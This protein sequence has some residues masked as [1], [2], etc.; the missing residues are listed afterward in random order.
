MHFSILYN[1]ESLGYAFF[2]K[3]A[4]PSDHFANSSMPSRNL[5]ILIISAVV[6]LLCYRTATRHHYGG[7]L[8]SAIGKINESFVRP[9]DDRELFEGA[10]HGMVRQLDPHSVYISPD[11]VQRFQEELDQE[12]GGIGIVVEINAT[13]RRLTVLSPLPDTPAF[14]AGMRA[15]DV[16]LDINDESTE[17]FQI[18][19][20][21]GLMRG[22]PGT[23]LTLTIQHA[24]AT[25]PIGLKLT[26]AIIP[27]ASVLGDLRNPDGSWQFTLQKHPRIGYIRLVGFGEHTAD[28]LS[29]TIRSLD[30]RID[31]LVI[32]LRGNGGGLLE[33]AVAVC[34]LFIDQGT[35][36]SIRGRDPRRWRDYTASPT[37]TLLLSLP[38][39]V[40]VDGY[41]ASASEIMAACMQDNGRAIIVGERS[42]GKGTVQNVLPFEG[43]KSAL[44]L[45][46]ATYWR[47][48]GQNIHR[49]RD[50][51]ENDA[52]GVSPN[53]GYEV[54]LT[55]EQY[56]QVVLAR[57]ER[58]YVQ[59]ETQDTDDV[60]ED[61]ASP[62]ET[63]TTSEGTPDLAGFSDPQLQRA[64]E[65]LED[66]ISRSPGSG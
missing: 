27:I 42:W 46:V 34:D 19:D 62:E 47:P 4:I 17:G 36:V 8:A 7:L 48:N 63:E 40:L 11:E 37:N 15:G 6:S 44:K 49:H 51:T 31:G 24:G 20:A 56:R 53:E 3:S 60:A 23:T 18:S 66:W 32:E 55:D 58:D 50:M 30:S 64:I 38:M 65:A 13:T 61:S 54:K 33:S 57:R 45:T 16:I 35:I 2:V 5:A 29:D 59:R 1:S 26:R 14:A 28:E 9:M 10:M 41:S 52:W 22:D 39:V 25:Q 43:G 21:V 12:F